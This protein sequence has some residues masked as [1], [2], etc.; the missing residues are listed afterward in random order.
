MSKMCLHDPFGHIKHKLW[1]KEG[2]KIVNSI[3][4]DQKLGISLIFLRASGVPH[5]VGKIS[6]RDTTL[7]ETSP[8]SEVCTQSYELPKSWKYKF[9]EF[10]D[11]NLGCPETK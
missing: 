7:L 5:T 10:W 3:L 8:Q 9:K 11:S 1:P 2:S 4:D 6:M